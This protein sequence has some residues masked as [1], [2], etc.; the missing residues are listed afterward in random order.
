MSIPHSRFRH[1][2]RKQLRDVIVWRHTAGDPRI[3]RQ[4]MRIVI[5][6]TTFWMSKQML[7]IYAKY[8]A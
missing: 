5:F 4:F 1:M 2:S 8:K 7:R 3:V 6:L